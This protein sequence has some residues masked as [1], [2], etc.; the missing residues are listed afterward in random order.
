[1]QIEVKK[2]IPPLYWK[3]LVK[4]NWTNFA[5]FQNLNKMGTSLSLRPKIKY[6]LFAVADRPT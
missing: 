2:K 3:L 4:L 5:S 6:C 1:M